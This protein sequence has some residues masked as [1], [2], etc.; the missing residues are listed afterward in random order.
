MQ[1]LLL[2]LFAL[3]VGLVLEDKVIPM[4]K[5]VEKLLFVSP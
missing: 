1:Y 4:L 5:D 3:L 2:V